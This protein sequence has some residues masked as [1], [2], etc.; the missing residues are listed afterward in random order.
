MSGLGVNP[1]DL[2][3]A[4]TKLREAISYA[5]KASEYSTEADPEW[6][7]WGVAGLVTAPLYFALAD[8]WRDLLK[9]TGEAID[10]LSQRLEDSKDGYVEID[11]T[12]GEGFA[13]LLTDLS[14]AAGD[15]KSNTQNDPMITQT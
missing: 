13:S 8:G 2:T 7:M 6:W 11:S 9:E 15:Y 5:D 14:G 3:A 12:I 10:G 1:D 4:A